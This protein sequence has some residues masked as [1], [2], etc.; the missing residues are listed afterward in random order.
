MSA[1]LLQSSADQFVILT[2]GMTT[3]LD[4]VVDKISVMSTI[5]GVGLTSS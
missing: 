4:V 2:V 3:L 1:L 5:S